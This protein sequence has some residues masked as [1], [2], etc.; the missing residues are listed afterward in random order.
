MPSSSL[1]F[2]LA[3]ASTSGQIVTDTIPVWY[4]YLGFGIAF[5]AL[6]F[7]FWTLYN[8]GSIATHRRPFWSRFRRR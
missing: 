2:F 5:I 7:I 3:V 4:F 1:A 6:G 8:A